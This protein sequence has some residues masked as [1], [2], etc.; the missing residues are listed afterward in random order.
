MTCD[1][2]APLL[3][4]ENEKGLSLELVRSLTN[5]LKHKA[6][7]EKGREIVHD[8]CVDIQEFLYLNNKP[9]AKSFYEQRLENQLKLTTQETG[10]D[11]DPLQLAAKKELAANKAAEDNLLVS[12]HSR[13]K[14]KHTTNT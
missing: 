5:Q 11:E 14:T 3:K 7:A 12:Q 4:L 13:Q 1:I 10:V 8:I 2:R 6:E 9:P